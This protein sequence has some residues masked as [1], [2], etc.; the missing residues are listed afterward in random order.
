MVQEQRIASSIGRLVRQWSLAGNPLRS[1]ATST[2]YDHLVHIKVIDGEG[3]RHSFTGIEGQTLAELIREHSDVLGPQAVA[4]SPEG[5]GRV[6]AH[7]KI[8][9]EL[10]DAIPAPRG[11]DEQWMKEVAD[12]YALDE[13]SRLGSR[14]VLDKSMDGVIVSIGDIYPYKTL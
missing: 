14:I 10:F 13:H 12:P 1:M 11:D 4:D 6:E 7:V 2:V 5:R 8:P 3:H 9:T